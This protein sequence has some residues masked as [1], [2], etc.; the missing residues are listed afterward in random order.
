MRAASAQADGD[1]STDPL[2]KLTLVIV[3]SSSVFLEIDEQVLNPVYI[4]GAAFPGV[5]EVRPQISVIRSASFHCRLQ[6]PTDHASAIARALLEMESAHVRQTVA[7][8]PLGTSST[9]DSSLMGYR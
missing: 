1:Q 6:I 4:P 3:L 7:D 2:E 9:G 5:R 8:E